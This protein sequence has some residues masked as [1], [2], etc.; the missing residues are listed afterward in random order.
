MPKPTSTPLSTM[1]GQACG[2]SSFQGAFLE[3][4]SQGPFSHWLGNIEDKYLEFQFSEEWPMV[5]SWSICSLRASLTSLSS[6]GRL[7]GWSPTCGQTLS[8][9]GMEE[10]TSWCKHKMVRVLN[11][12]IC[13]FSDPTSPEFPIR[14]P[15]PSWQPTE[16]I[17]ERWTAYLKICFQIFFLF[18]KFVS[19]LEKFSAHLESLSQ[20]VFL[21]GRYGEKMQATW[22]SINIQR[23]WKIIFLL[24]CFTCAYFITLVL[25][26][27]FRTS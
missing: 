1:E 12:Q 15:D 4:R 27:F 16:E 18:K 19:Y 10:K 8:F 22:E 11:L 3:I 6:T 14:I 23:S 13:S 21:G 9:T 17:V 25:S 7:P 20:R 5:M 26:R 2:T 24:T